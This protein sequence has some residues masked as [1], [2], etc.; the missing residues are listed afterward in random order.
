[1]VAHPIVNARLS[2]LREHSTS[3]KE[4]REV[5]SALALCYPY[6]CLLTSSL[7]GIHEISLLLGFEASRDLE[8]ETFAGVRAHCNRVVPTQ[9]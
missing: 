5:Y 3:T 7:Q 1:M 6:V 8:E 9:I 4:F 2:K